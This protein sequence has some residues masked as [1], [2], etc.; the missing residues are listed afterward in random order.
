MTQDVH[1]VAAVDEHQ[2]TD[3]LQQWTAGDKASLEHLFPI[4]Y[5]RL[6]EKAHY[7]LRKESN[8]TL[9][10]TSLINEVYL[11]LCESHNL[12]FKNRLQFF[13][14]AGQLMHRI[15]VERARA[16]LASKRG[17]GSTHLS[18]EDKDNLLSACNT[19]PSTLLSLDEVLRKLGG[20]DK[21][22]F[23]IVQLWFFAG[24]DAKE[25]GSLLALSAATVRRELQAAK[26]WMAFELR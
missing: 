3:F 18:F 26:C 25:I 24:L 5:Q 11:R 21:R 15:L 9:Q 20:F 7:F 8:A 10:T 19:D 23:R 14:F 6:K 16:R 2:I 13:S 12:K 22:K 4:V 1:P 17:G